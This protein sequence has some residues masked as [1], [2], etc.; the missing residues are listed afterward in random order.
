MT[1]AKAKPEE[2]AFIDKPNRTLL[3]LSIPVLF[4]LIAE[5]VTGLV[6]TAFITQ[7]GSA[8]LAALGIATAALSSVF[9]IFNFL[10]ISAQTNVAQALG[11][12]KRGEAKRNASLAFALA[13][14]ISIAVGILGTFAAPTIVELLGAK[15]AVA[16]DAALYL[17]IRLIGAPAVLLSLTGFGVLR[18]MQDMRTPMWIAIGVNIINVV[19]DFPLIF[20]TGSFAGFGVAGSAMA[21]VIAQ[22]VGVAWLLWEIARRL[23]YT[24]EFNFADAISLIQV[25]GDLFLRTGLMTL[26]LLLMTRI[27]NQISIESGAAHQ[28]IRQA[29]MFTAL[30]LDALAITVQSL[31]GYFLGANR[32]DMAK[33]AAAYSVGWSLIVGGLMTLL[34][35]GTMPYVVGV[36][37]PVEAADIFVGAWIIAAI[38]QPLNSMAFITDGIHWGTGDYTYL[39]N[40]MFVAV[41]IAGGAAFLIDINSANAFTQV[42]QVTALWI[43]V[44]GILG[45]LR[46][47]PGIGDAPLN[48]QAAPIT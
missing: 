48:A 3:L 16:T 25:G 12:S 19:L 47:F 26:F 37:V 4:S 20:G 32:V 28:S 46:V 7:L 39:R 24:R 43:A 29:W 31:V 5:P 33:R 13:F 35:F 8:P 1:T 45:L 10:G 14:A 22:Y 41:L 11:Q 6:D 34:M 18:G 2:H 42:W 15:D 23:G 17:R 36:I 9:W 27:A 21:T 30:V 44:R 40:A 38:T